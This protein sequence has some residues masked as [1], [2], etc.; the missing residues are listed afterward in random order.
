[1]A[2]PSRFISRLRLSQFR[3]YQAAAL[4]SDGRHVV[5]VGPNGSGKTN[6]LEAISLLN[7]GRGLRGAPFEE[8]A[9][10]GSDGAWAVAMTVETPDGPADIGTGSAGPEGGRRVRINGANAR[11]VEQLAD[12][13]RVLWLTPAMDGLFTGPGG[14]RRR[15]LDRLITA[16]LPGHSA[17]VS[18]FEKAMRQRNRLVEEDAEP[19]WIGAV[20]AQM[21]ES[22]AAIHFAR[23]DSLGL[24][25]AMS[26]EGLAEQSFP[27]ARLALTPLLTDRDVPQSSAS[28]EAELRGIWQNG[29]AVDRAA[30]RTLI[31]PHRVDFEIR[32][33]QKDM[34]AALGSTGEQK[35]LL[36]GLILAQARLVRSASGFAPILLLDEIAAHLD[37]GRRE[38]LFAALDALGTQCFMTGTD[39]ILFQALGGRAQLINV[40]DGRLAPER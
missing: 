38:A 22:A 35:A 15:F 28:L 18:D 36:I 31:G 29:R 33:A 32:H 13:L 14:D 19:A 3:N 37:P 4:D 5:L 12:Y 16:L 1:M 2:Q 8:V 26:L 39:P 10:L 6:L 34:P 25:Q 23:A 40:R 11:T 27:A 21:A 30:G 24:L 20:E 9:A 17:Q 7:P